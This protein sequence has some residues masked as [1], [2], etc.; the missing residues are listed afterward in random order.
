MRGTCDS[1]YYL[2]QVVV[3]MFRSDSRTREYP[4]S[5]YVKSLDSTAKSRYLKKL[6][7]QREP[8]RLPDPYLECL[9]WEDNSLPWSDVTFGAIYT[10]YVPH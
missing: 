7:Y 5:P 1:T 6:E 8:D 3:S 2:L 9:Q 4:L 10:V